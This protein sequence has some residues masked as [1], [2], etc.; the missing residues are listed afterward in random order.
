MGIAVHLNGKH[1]PDFPLFACL[2]LF[3]RGPNACLV[4]NVPAKHLLGDRQREIRYYRVVEGGNAPHKP[5]GCGEQTLEKSDYYEV[6]I[7]YF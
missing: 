7:A 4:P 6:I 5:L 1:L 2:F 3:L